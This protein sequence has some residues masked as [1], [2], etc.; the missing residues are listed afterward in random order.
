MELADKEKI[1]L[2]KCNL[3]I[4]R[5]MKGTDSKHKACRLYLLCP[6]RAN[7]G[8]PDRGRRLDRRRFPFPHNNSALSG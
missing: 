2:K 1:P 6:H 5:D 3:P 8:D 7:E 4:S